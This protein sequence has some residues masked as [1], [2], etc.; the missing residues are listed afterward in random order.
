MQT[1]L[2]SETQRVSLY[3]TLPDESRTD[4]KNVASF[5]RLF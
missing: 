1:V 2:H 5:Q 4:R 3:E